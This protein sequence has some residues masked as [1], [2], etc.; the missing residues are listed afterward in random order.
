MGFMDA[1]LGGPA[2]RPPLRDEL[3][4]AGAKMARSPDI[5]SSRQREVRLHPGVADGENPMNLHPS[6]TL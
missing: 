5:G 6:P 3:R 4:S 1:H 2:A